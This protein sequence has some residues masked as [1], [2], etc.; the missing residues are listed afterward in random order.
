MSRWLSRTGLL[1]C[2]VVIGATSLASAQGGVCSFL[3]ATKETMADGQCFMFSLPGSQV[4]VERRYTVYGHQIC[5]GGHP[6]LIYETAT[7]EAEGHGACW[8]I[9]IYDQWWFGRCDPLWHENL[10]PSAHTW[11]LRVHHSEAFLI[12]VFPVCTYQAY[13]DFSHSVS[14][15]HC[16]Q[17]PCPFPAPPPYENW[18]YMGDSC[19]N[20]WLVTDWYWCPD[21]CYYHHSEFEF[22]GFICL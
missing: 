12:D 14:Q 20:V 7:F 22:L 9:N 11:S 13:T 5:P 17:D 21:G 4:D 16:A 18:D 2:L 15:R 3:N 6:Q 10:N 1:T 8:G 19:Y